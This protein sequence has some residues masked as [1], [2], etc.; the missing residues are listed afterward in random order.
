[1]PCLQYAGKLQ[2]SARS[3]AVTNPTWLAP[4]IMREEEF[5][6]Q[7]DVYSYGVIAW[8]LLTRSHPFI[9]FD[10][11]FM[12]ELEDHVKAGGRATVPADCPS[13]AS[14][15]YCLLSV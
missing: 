10:F 4:E 2:E 7:S 9:E 12:G 14:W 11:K 13:Q 3:R 8:E 6:V 15:S 1:M 5:R